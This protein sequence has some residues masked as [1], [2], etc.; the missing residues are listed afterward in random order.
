MDHPGRHSL[1]ALLR[2]GLEAIRAA[3]AVLLGADDAD[4]RTGGPG[5]A[6]G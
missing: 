1:R 3:I 2:T 4:S 6:V 5:G